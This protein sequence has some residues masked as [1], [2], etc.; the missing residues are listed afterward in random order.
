MKFI[1]QQKEYEI[2]PK[3]TISLNGK[4]VPT[5]TLK[6]NKPFVLE[7]VFTA[8]DI[9][10][11]QETEGIKFYSGSELAKMLKSK[12]EV[13]FSLTP[14]AV[15]FVK[16][17]AEKT[18]TSLKTES[19]KQTIHKWFW[20]IGGDSGALYVSADIDTEF[21]PELRAIAETIEKTRARG[22]ILQLLRDKSALS[23]RKTALYTDGWFE[24]SNDDMMEIYN[25]IIAKEDEVGKIEKAKQ[26]RREEEKQAIFETAKTTGEK[27]ILYKMYDE[28]DDPREECSM[29]EIIAYAM[30][31]GTIKIA[32]N[33]TY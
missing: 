17:E 22:N 14:E 30:P 15:A 20:A 6:I 12:Q 11:R 32:R 26:E 16:E 21:R 9:A 23:D 13:L 3:S 4:T 25:I 2:E 33:H 10:V 28:C 27:Q 5:F 18:T 19:E 24:I 8:Y 7:T 1:T 31:D 29:D